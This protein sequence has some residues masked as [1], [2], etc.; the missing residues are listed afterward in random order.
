MNEIR[1]VILTIIRTINDDTH[2][3]VGMT[4]RRTD[5][6]IVT[7]A[8][9]LD[10]ANTYIT[11]IRTHINNISKYKENKKKVL[12]EKKQTNNTSTCDEGVPPL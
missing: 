12:E 7:I 2:V 11:Y 8:F 4:L 9:P 1:Q 10:K 5:T 6:T 3:A